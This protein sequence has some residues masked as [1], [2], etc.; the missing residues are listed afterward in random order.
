MQ[1]ATRL[2]LKLNSEYTFGIVLK[3]VF[4]YTNIL[5]FISCVLGA[6]L[7]AAVQNDDGLIYF[8][9]NVRPLLLEECSKCHGEKKQKGGLRLDLPQYI[10]KGGDS[11]TAFISGNA[12]HSL[13]IKAVKG[14]LSDLRMPPKT[15]L[16]STQIEHLSNWINS[17]APLPSFDEDALKQTKLSGDLTQVKQH[18]SFQPITATKL[19]QVPKQ[20]VVQNAIDTFIYDKL[21]EKQLR[22]SG[23]AEPLILLR[24]LCLDLV[25]LP[26]TQQQIE[27]FLSEPIDIAYPKM[28]DALLQSKH[29]GE[30]WAKHWLNLVR[31][32]ESTGKDENHALPYAY[33]YRD[34]VIQAFNEDLPYH[35]FIK[36]QLASDLFVNTRS[37]QEQLKHLPAT[38]FNMFGPK[39]IAERDL[40][41]LCMDV[42][43]EQLD[44]IS[45]TFLGLTMS[46]A[47][48]HDHKFDPISTKDYYA[49]AGILK[50]TETLEDWTPTAIK[51]HHYSSM[52]TQTEQAH[53]QPLIAQIK[54]KLT[55]YKKL[56]DNKK[57]TPE[58]D[59]SFKLLADAIATLKSQLIPEKR[60]YT[61]TDFPLENATHDDR[62]IQNCRVHVRGSYQT[63]KGEPIVRSV[64]KIFE[65]L[66]ASEPV[67]ENQS[68]RVQLANW[69]AHASNPLTAK[70]MVNRIWTWHFG[71]GLVSSTSNFGTTGT[72]PSH[73]ELLDWLTKDF[74][75]H[76]W[77]IKHLQQRIVNSA[78][79]QQS[80]DHREDASAIDPDR[81]YLWSFP[82][83]R[84][85]A[86]I[87]RDRMLTVSG[88]IDPQQGKPFFDQD[89]FLEKHRANGL[90]QKFEQSHERS[91]YLPVYRNKIYPMFKVFN[92]NSASMPNPQRENT[93]LSTQSLFLY[94]SPYVISR[95]Q[96]C[97]KR[98]LA[99]QSD[100]PSRIK[101]AY[102][103]IY[104]REANVKEIELL[105]QY[106]QHFSQKYPAPE[107]VWTL[108]VQSLF[109]TQEFLSLN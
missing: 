37:E 57:R 69:I 17:G 101:T 22:F 94:N 87:I 96:A 14:V 71:K 7:I 68:G 49:L 79:Y 43:D 73:P 99:L 107:K 108:I 81:T 18:W 38:A 23:K 53:N 93:S 55:E 95:A 98:L 76:N 82:P 78:T 86:E 1:I 45:L 48:C 36:E 91:I 9:K 70:V 65:H 50:S 66:Y 8:E 104:Q 58:Q 5:S 109:L 85:D 97:A 88:E 35:Q 54:S 41:Q 30:K 3:K 77:S 63:Q 2:A 44:N 102:M 92:F 59:N 83:Q 29:Y 62:E 32:A 64:P 67:P 89:P 60:S 40:N 51:T 6:H 33:T 21:Q 15:H 13:M 19:P 47:R 4:L 25:G 11:G 16:T 12:E 80:S 74:I 56:E 100:E 26:P 84:L 34:Y 31:Y 20:V 75:D 90:E 42:I 24:R 105:S 61:L 10:F 52:L 46:C 39:N 103:Q 28:V 106:H 27:T 72:E